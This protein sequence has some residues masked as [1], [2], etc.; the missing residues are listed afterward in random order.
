M[1]SIFIG[2]YEREQDNFD[3]LEDAAENVAHQKRRRYS[4]SDALHPRPIGRESKPEIYKVILLGLVFGLRHGEIDMLERSSFDF[5]RLRLVLHNT[6]FFHLKTVASEDVLDMEDEVAEELKEMMQFGNS[7]FFIE[8]PRP[9]K[10]PGALRYYRCKPVFD[11]AMAWLR[12][13]GI[14]SDKPLHMLRKEVGAEVA[15]ALGIYAAQGYLRHS[16]IAT[17]AAIYADQKKRVTP[18]FGSVFKAL[19][20]AA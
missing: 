13:I 11:E 1:A 10:P 15:S 5:P 6:E 4:D 14:K 17:T 18:G 8:S 7:R 20:K 9:P 3:I 19:P 16:H 12:K 2:N